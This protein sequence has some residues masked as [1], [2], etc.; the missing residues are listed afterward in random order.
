M[1]YSEGASVSLADFHDGKELRDEI[2]YKR[3]FTIGGRKTTIKAE[4]R[5]IRSTVKNIKKRDKQIVDLYNMARKVY[6]FY[7]KAPDHDF[8]DH[9]GLL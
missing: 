3:K 5:R 7:F 4:E 2:L 8:D 9:H 1:A 6:F